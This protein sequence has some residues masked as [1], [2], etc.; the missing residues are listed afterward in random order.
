[1]LIG[2]AVSI[3]RVV[4]ACGPAQVAVQYGVT[5][6]GLLIAAWCRAFVIEVVVGTAAISTLGD[7]VAGHAYIGGVAELQAVL[8][9]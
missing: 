7:F 8:A 9:D 3:K 6:G 5:A 1:V 2:R 4:V